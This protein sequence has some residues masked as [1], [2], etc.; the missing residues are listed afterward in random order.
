NNAIFGENGYLCEEQLTGRSVKRL[1]EKIDRETAAEAQKNGCPHCRGRLHRANYKRKVRG[2]PECDDWNLRDSFC[3]AEDDCRRRLTPE[4]VR[5]LGRRVYAGFIVV[6]VSA[7][8]H[9][10]KPERL[11]RM[12][13]VLNIDRRTVERWRQWWLD[14]FVRGSFWRAARGRFMPAVDHKTLPWS[15]CQR[16]DWLIEVLKFLAPLSCPPVWA[17]HVM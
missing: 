1:C 9:G 8:M 6:L 3:C 5:F 11:E 12:R 2:A 15:L 17:E 14:A 10:L 4:S 16:F 13:E 7:M